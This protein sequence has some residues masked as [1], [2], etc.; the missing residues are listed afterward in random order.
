MMCKKKVVP[1]YELFV[2]GFVITYFL[3]LVLH[4]DNALFVFLQD[5]DTKYFQQLYLS[6]PA[7]HDCV[8]SSY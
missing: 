5:L 2:P 8:V 4:H 3:K 1:N 6:P 7:V